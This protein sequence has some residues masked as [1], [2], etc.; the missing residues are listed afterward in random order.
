MTTPTKKSIK[1]LVPILV[2]AFALCAALP[3]GAMV[4]N[5]NGDKADQSASTP[6]NGGTALDQNDNSITHSDPAVDLANQIMDDPVADYELIESIRFRMEHNN[7]NLEQLQQIKNSLDDQVEVFNPTAETQGLGNIVDLGDQ[8][9]NQSFH[10]GWQSSYYENFGDGYAIENIEVYDSNFVVAVGRNEDASNAF[11]AINNGEEWSLTDLEPYEGYQGPNDMLTS[12]VVSRDDIY[13]GGKG[14]L[15]Y[16]YDGNEWTLQHH[17]MGTQ[18]LAPM[19]YKF[20]NYGDEIYALGKDNNENDILKKT[21]SGAWETLQI[22]GGRDGYLCMY[23]DAQIVDSD[24]GHEMYLLCE[25]SNGQTKVEKINLDSLELTTVV[26]KLD[27]TSRFVYRFN[28]ESSDEMYFAVGAYQDEYDKVIVLKYDHGNVTQIEANTAEQD[29]RLIT[30]RDMEKDAN[31]VYWLAGTYGVVATMENDQISVNAADLN[32]DGYRNEDDWYSLMSV[33][34]HL[35]VAYL[36]TR[37][38]EETPI[39]KL[40]DPVKPTVNFSGLQSVY[41][42]GDEMDIELT[43]NNVNG[44]DEEIEVYIVLE[45][46]GTTDP[47][48]YFWPNWSQELGKK[49][50]K[51]NAGE[52]VHEEVINF[53]LPDE[54]GAFGPINMYGLA[55]AP[56]TFSVFS[57]NVASGSFSFQ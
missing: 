41:N 34:P 45:I 12:M 13:V 25:A 51:V 2:F 40:G 15:I 36:S 23:W 47:L 24:S 19:V 11:V 21:A 50:I 56:G 6:N 52:T 43:I 7:L 4:L 3:A 10:A 48:Y 27:D 5:Y 22:N 9:F 57:G 39:F 42:G 53:T 32:G 28:V 33:S 26:D 20:M 8:R 38:D 31:G 17:Y 37:T 18:E 46:P 35:N 49:A 54:L 30:L 1:L 16:H 44:G 55:A 14:E 29:T